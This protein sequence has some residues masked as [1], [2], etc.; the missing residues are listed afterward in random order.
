MKVL[1]I[2]TGW[3]GCHLACHLLSQGHTV[4]LVDKSNVFFSGS[5]SKNQNRLHLGYHYPRSP[6]TIRECIDGYERFTVTYPQLLQQ[7]PNN[8]YFIA[9]HGSKV[10]FENYIKLFPDA[11]IHNSPLPLPIDKVETNYIRCDEQFISFEK[12]RSFFQERL[13]KYFVKIDDTEVFKSI[14]TI[15]QHLGGE[16]DYTLNCTYNHLEPIEFD[17]YEL[18][19]TLLY[20]VDSPDLFAYTIMDGNYFS[21]YPYSIEDR[22][23]TL[24]SVEHGVISSEADIDR[25]RAKIEAG[26]LE[27]IPSWNEKTQ[28]VSYYVSY[29]TKPKTQTDDR[30]L[31]HRV[32]GNT[33]HFYGGK[34]TGVFRAEA[35]L[36]ELMLFTQ[37][38]TKA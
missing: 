27:F 11:T 15:S 20:R 26:I 4:V 2:G 7:I 1:V 21:L 22:V 28:Y 38:P 23:Y 17:H 36:D 18:F 14:K 9:S 10:T 31:R 37:T 34:I 8:Y 32:D 13:D 16:F 6:D 3:Y 29:K 24:T 33:V 35:I 12:A 30:S 19:L 5:S 25:H